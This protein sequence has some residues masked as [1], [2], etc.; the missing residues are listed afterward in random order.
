MKQILVIDDEELVREGIKEALTEEG[1]IVHTAANGTEAIK[2]LQILIPDVIITDIIMP[3]TDGI[4]VLLY[5]KKLQP[6]PKII[7]ISG[8]GRISANDHLSTA[9]KLGADETLA[10]PFSIDLLIEKIER[11]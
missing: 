9:R 6:R 3:E 5:A 11:N 7:A 2:A 4:E 1:Y 8:G 10:K